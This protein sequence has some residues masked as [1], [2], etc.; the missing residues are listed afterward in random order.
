MLGMIFFLY[1]LGDALKTDK[2]EELQQVTQ[3]ETNTK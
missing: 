1:L 3:M 2:P